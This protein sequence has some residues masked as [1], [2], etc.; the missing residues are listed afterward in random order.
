MAG[1]LDA[2]EALVLVRVGPSVDLTTYARRRQPR[3]DRS[4]SINVLA[5]TVLR[6]LGRRRARLQPLQPG[7]VIA[8]RWPTCSKRFGV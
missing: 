6:G 8:V 2:M 5:I 4:G 1:L 7:V 3:G